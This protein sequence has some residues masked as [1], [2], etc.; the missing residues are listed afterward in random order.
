ML[1]LPWA[2]RHP[3]ASKAPVTL[4]CWGDPQGAPGEDRQPRGKREPHSC[5]GPCIHTGQ[6][7]QLS[8]PFPLL[9]MRPLETVLWGGEVLR[10]RPCVARSLAS[11][12]CQA[13]WLQAAPP[14]TQGRAFMNFSGVPWCALHTEKGEPQLFFVRGWMSHVPV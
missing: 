9:C 1:S 3:R 11:S 5:P 4:I 8:L 10:R 14:V 2:P 13:T 7:A 12:S 6:P